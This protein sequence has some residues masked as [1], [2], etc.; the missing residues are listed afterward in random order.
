[1]LKVIFE[2]KLQEALPVFLIFERA[3]K[4]TFK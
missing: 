2:E 1:M 4:L 3:L